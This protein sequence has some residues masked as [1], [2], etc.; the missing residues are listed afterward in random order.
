MYCQVCGFENIEGGNFCKR[1]GVGLSQQIKATDSGVDYRKL[2][3]M[4]WAVAVF[5][6][7]S[8][9]MLIGAMIPLAIVGAR[10]DI[11]I[12]TMFFGA[13]SIVTIAVLLIRQLARLVDLARGEA[14][15]PTV[16]DKLANR[17][18][19]PHPPAQLPAQPRSYSSV[20]EN[21]TR[22]FE[23]PPVY[24]DPGARE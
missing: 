18:S 20:T 13:A 12:P 10:D 14:N 15:R 5:G 16:K 21:T 3:G 19:Q 24:R 4:F 17:Y 2:A 1:C 11:V 6:L 22:N 23:P 7:V 9:T 8:I